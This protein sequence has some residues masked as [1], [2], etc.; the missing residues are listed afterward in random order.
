MIGKYIKIHAST[1]S[2]MSSNKPIL[3]LRSS[4]QTLLLRNEIQMTRQDEEGYQIFIKFVRYAVC[5]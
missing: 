3:P 5:A 1:G 4:L 2:G